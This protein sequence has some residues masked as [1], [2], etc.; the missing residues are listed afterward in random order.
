MILTSWYP[1]ENNK[2]KG[3][4][5]REQ[6]LA[7]KKANAPVAVFYPFDEAVPAG[8]L[9]YQ[10]E[11]GIPTYR[12]N[13]NAWKNRYLSRLAGY[14]S[15]L[16]NL[17]RVTQDFKPDLIH[18]HVSYPAGIL[19]YLFTLKYKI[20]YLI[21]EHMS[22]LQNY[23][24]KWQHR[25]LLRPALTKAAAVLPVSAFL[26]QQIKGF[27]WRVNIKP[28]PNV[29]DTAR[30]SIH[31][32]QA[33]PIPASDPESRTSDLGPRTSE[34]R[35]RTSDGG[36]RVSI[37][38]VGHMDATQVKGLQFL[39]PAL[40]EVVH[41][42]LA[43]SYCRQSVP[44]DSGKPNP[45]DSQPSGDL[46]LHLIGEGP[47]RQQY[48]Q[49]VTELGITDYCTFYG[50]VDPAKMPEFYRKTDFLVLPSLKE[51]FG[52]VLIEAMASGKPVLA[53]DCGGPT[54]IV[55]KNTGILVEP[56]SIPSLVA[57]LE[58]ML[59]SLDQYDPQQIRQ[60]ALD[61]YSPEAVAGKLINIYRTVL[62]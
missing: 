40:A 19:A 41:R 33:L 4:F 18:V 43:L 42:K 35:R 39:L 29:V 36:H 57:G 17:R 52:C 48:E 12:H 30:F 45:A 25:M 46:H 20:P 14:L 59:A 61:N 60:Y 6:A 38:F 37:L 55:N 13:S 34:I 16:R 51:T 22:Y 2:V 27:G 44:L 54:G 5:V 49:M 31:S 56:G 21:T 50:R 32:S 47:L 53:T 24:D 7:L 9:V 15:S 8:Q 1:N 62:L 58:K 26:G 10:V 23:V 28:V 3:I 11:D